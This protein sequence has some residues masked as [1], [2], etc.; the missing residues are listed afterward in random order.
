MSDISIISNQANRVKS[1]P[2]KYCYQSKK[3]IT[4]LENYKNKIEKTGTSKKKKLK[5]CHT[6]NEHDETPPSQQKCS[7]ISA[8]YSSFL[9]CGKKPEKF[10][11]T[12]QI[13]K[14]W[15]FSFYYQKNIILLLQPVWVHT[16]LKF[17]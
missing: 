17:L 2:H 7:L 1:L 14:N 5:K 6:L 15:T 4:K 16:H 8:V 11:M 9:P 10:V 3:L 13:H 12:T